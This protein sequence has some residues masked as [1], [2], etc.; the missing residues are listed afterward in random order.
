MKRTENNFTLIELLVVI[1]IIAILAAMLL[2]A[3]GRA[4]EVAKQAKCQSNLKQLGTAQEMYV[5]SYDGIFCQSLNGNSNPY[6]ATW[7]YYLTPFMSHKYASDTNTSDDYKKVF[8]SGV[9]LC[10]AKRIFHNAMG[11]S[12]GMNRNLDSYRKA[13]VKKPSLCLLMADKTDYYDN[14][15]HFLVEGDFNTRIFYGDVMNYTRHGNKQAEMLF[16][17]GHVEGVKQ[18]YAKAHYNG[19][20]NN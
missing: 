6:F 15:P 5:D 10:P 1:A 11:I 17:D 20:P 13:R 14:T 8:Q 2:P 19:K 18:V 4:R 16:T 7:V 9:V 12:Y 3:L